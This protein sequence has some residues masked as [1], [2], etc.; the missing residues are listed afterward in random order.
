VHIVAPTLDDLIRDVLEKLVSDGRRISPSKGGALE[1]TGVLLELENPRARLSQTEMRGKLFSSLGELCWYLARNGDV[2]FM[3]YYIRDYRSYVEVDGSDKVFGAYGPRLFNHHGFD[4]VAAALQLLQTR[5]SSRRAVLV[6][7]GADDL[8]GSHKEVPCTCTLQFLLRE[9]RLHMMVSMRSNDAYT[10]I[11]HDVFSFTMIQEIAARVLSV[12]V[13]GYKHFAGSLHL[14]DD[15]RDAADRFLQEG[16]QPTSTAM[17][18]MPEENPWP[19]IR[20]LLDAE[21]N[22]RES[23]TFNGSRYSTLDSYWLDLIHLLRIW[24][25]KTENSSEGILAMRDDIAFEGYKPFIDSRLGSM[26]EKTS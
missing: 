14:Y 1:L 7:L 5:P 15:D 2:A 20:L 23:G 21:R 3:E 17:P 24:R 12:E 10:G 19:S 16:W 9:E 18:P 8:K 26:S 22:L 11:V 4:Q 25:C 6:I 13:G